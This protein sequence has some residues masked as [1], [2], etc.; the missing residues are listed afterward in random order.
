MFKCRGVIP[1]VHTNKMINFHV[2]LDLSCHIFHV[3]LFSVMKIKNLYNTT[4][5]S[6]SSKTHSNHIVPRVAVLR[7]EFVGEQ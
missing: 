4:T 2:V 6:F 5:R 3:S 7:E 1:K